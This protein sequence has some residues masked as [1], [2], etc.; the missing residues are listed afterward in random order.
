MGRLKRGKTPWRT[1]PT[2]VE[3]LG[4]DLWIGVKGQSNPVIAVLPEMHLGAASRFSAV[5]EHWWARGP[6]VTDSPKLRCRTQE[7]G[8]ET[9]GDKLRVERET[10]QIAS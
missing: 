7:R 9:A 3:N 2:R 4:D 1:E 10:A 8:S 5:V 6:K